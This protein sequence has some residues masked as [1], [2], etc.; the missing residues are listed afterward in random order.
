VLNSLARKIKALADYIK[1]SD[2]KMHNNSS[3]QPEIEVNALFLDYDGTISPINVPRSKSKVP[4]E[5]LA[6]LNKIREQIP[7]AIITTKP[8]QFVV[9]RTPFA[10]AWS[11]LGGLETKIG[12]VKAKAACLQRITPHIANALRYS[13]SLAKGILTIETKRDFEGV[14]VAFSIDWR[15]AKNR[16]RAKKTAMKILSFCE[17]LPLIT[18][19]HEGQP[20]FDVLPCVVKK[21][22]AL[23]ELK[24]KLALQTG[25]LYMG[26][27]TDDNSAF[28]A[29]DL[30][31]GV[32]HAETPKN[33]TY[34]FFIK[35]ED[36]AQFL[37]SLLDNGLCFNPEVLTGLHKSRE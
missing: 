10:H 28:A 23:L 34:N 8:L 1:F 37:N 14:V 9:K 17:N 27:S 13:R 31:I 11:G 19:K 20:F 4:S 5:T 30:A 16:V 25:V 36:M 22:E 24:Q 33:L 15:H 12:D 18:V 6:V 21:G 2:E 32:V 3:G 35:F 26:D 29:A 7:V